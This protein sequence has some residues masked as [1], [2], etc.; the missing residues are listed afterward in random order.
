LPAPGALATVARLFGKPTKEKK[1]FKRVITALAV[2]LAALAGSLAGGGAA[3]AASSGDTPV[4]TIA[5]FGGGDDSVAPTVTVRAVGQSGVSAALY[6]SCPSELICFYWDGGGNGF[7]YDFSVT[8]GSADWVCVTVGEP[9]RSNASS[10]ANRKSG[11]NTRV[12]KSVS[13]TCNPLSGAFTAPMYTGQNR[14]F[15]GT[16]WNDNVW[17]MKVSWT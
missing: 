16:V 10:Y 9:V 11:A 13:S 7:R 1:V 2:V 8:I 15:S 17:S 12:Y 3:Q 6:S 14:D 5:S 4:A